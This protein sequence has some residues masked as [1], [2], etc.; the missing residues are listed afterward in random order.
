MTVWNGERFLDEAIRSV[1]EQDFADFEL[2]IVDDGSTDATPMI[3]DRWASRDARLRILRNATNLGIAS[4]ANIGLAVARGAYVARLDADDLCMPGRFAAQIDVL[5]R[6]RDVVL[7]STCYELID[8]HGR[9]LDIARRS[10]PPEVIAHLMHFSN[11][12]GGHSQVM[13]RRDVVRELGGYDES[14]DVCVDYEL[15]SRLIRRGR[16]IVLPIIGMK[17]RLHSARVS[18]VKRERQRQNSQCIANGLLASLFGEELPNDDLA[19]LASVWRDEVR[20]ADPVRAHRVFTRAYD[21][22]CARNDDAHHRACVRRETAR[23]WTSAAFAFARQGELRQAVTH[24]AYAMRW[25]PRGL[26]DGVAALLSR[27]LRSRLANRR[28][29]VPA[30]AIGGESK[31]VSPLA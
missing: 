17:Y 16:F 10:A 20:R 2:I 26:L 5:D 29:S 14:F 3:L 12:I 22:F 23:R 1:L 4:A 8:E 19:A 7:V 6:D 24:F 18:V 30:H 13:F 21:L 15:W 28:R 25:H 11:A 31:S 27:T 9:T